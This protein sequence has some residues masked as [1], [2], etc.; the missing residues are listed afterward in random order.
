MEVLRKW[1][2]KM[3]PNR[4]QK[5]NLVCD[6]LSHSLYAHIDASTQ[7]AYLTSFPLEKVS[8]SKYYK[9]KG[10]EC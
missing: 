6:A 10:W 5:K 9:R 2:K 1:T 3:L 7:K 8:T 4:K